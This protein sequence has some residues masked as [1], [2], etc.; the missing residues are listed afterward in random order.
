MPIGRRRHTGDRAWR[1][2]R[3]KVLERDGWR[4]TK[5]GRAGKLEVDH[6]VPVHE[7]GADTMQNCRALCRTCHIDRHRRQPTETEAE[8]DAHLETFAGT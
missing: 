4:C 3:R 1:A 7:G 2:L 8:W 5:C 6:R